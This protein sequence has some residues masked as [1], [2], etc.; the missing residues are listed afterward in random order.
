MWIFDS[1]NLALVKIIEAHTSEILWID[2]APLDNFMDKRAGLML[3]CSK[4]NTVKIFDSINNFDEIR[5]I[6]DHKT[7]VV[8][9]R[10]MADDT[11]PD[12]KIISADCKGIINV[13][14]MDED[15]NL[16]EPTQ[17]ELTSWKIFSMAVNEGCF[18]LGCDKKVCIC[19]TRKNNTVVLK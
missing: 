13:R 15:L 4:D 19:E 10:F 7:A 18:L 9:A 12:L 11:D 1:I 17:K 5:H 14:S 8:S 16:T 6:Q 2:S 3:S